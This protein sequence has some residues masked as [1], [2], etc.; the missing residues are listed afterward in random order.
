MRFN[1]KTAGFFAILG[2]ASVM[3]AP[4]GAFSQSLSQESR[5]RQKTKNEW[6]NLAI[7]SGVVALYGLLKHDSTITFA[8]AAGALYSLHRYEEDRKSQS[9]IDRARA[10]MFSRRSFTR[11]GRR[12]VRR[13]VKKNGRTYYQFVRAR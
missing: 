6:R 7:G 12:Y 3:G 13:T 8:G 11:N 5:Q 10:A 1:R 9:R 2:A 4:V